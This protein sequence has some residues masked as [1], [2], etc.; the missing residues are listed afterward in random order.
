MTGQN[1]R[2]LWNF[3]R[4]DLPLGKSIQGSEDPRNPTNLRSFST[5][6]SC[7]F[8]YLVDFL[9]IFSSHALHRPPISIRTNQ[10]KGNHLGRECFRAYQAIGFIEMLVWQLLAVPCRELSSFLYCLNSNC[11]SDITDGDRALFP[12][13]KT[14][15]ISP[16]VK[17]QAIRWLVILIFLLP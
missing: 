1:W 8:I 13:R 11:Y 5:I 10:I 4:K 6:I 12:D 14:G 7:I 15:L 3:Y 17:R 2:G 16:N 9:M